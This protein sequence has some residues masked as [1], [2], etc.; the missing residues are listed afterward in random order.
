[1]TNTEIKKALYKQ[2]PIAKLQFIRIG[3][4][5]YETI[6][7]DD[8][9]LEIW[10]GFQVPVSDMGDTDYFPQMDAKLLNRYIVE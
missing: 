8:D 10:I 4:A 5:Y 7:R 9:S 2:K 6:I 3:V 1:M